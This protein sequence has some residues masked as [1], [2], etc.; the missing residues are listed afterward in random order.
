MIGRIRLRSLRECCEIVLRERVPG[1]LVETG[2]WRGG[3]CIMMAAVLAAHEELTRTVWGFDSFQ[4]LQPPDEAKYPED[5][6]DQLYRFPQLAVSVEEVV[7]NFRRMGLWGLQ[8]RLVKGW[9][10]D[11]VPAAPI[12][13]IAVLRLDGDLYESTIHVL[14]G[15]YPRLSAGAFCIVDDYGPC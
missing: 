4:D 1:D 5:R 15:F 11:T 6:G 14:H 12:E 8:V 9:F 3:A 7:E 2:I 13:R 10:N